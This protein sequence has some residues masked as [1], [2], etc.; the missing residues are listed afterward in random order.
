ML[1]CAKER[2]FGVTERDH[3]SLHDEDMFNFF[4]PD[5]KPS[6]CVVVAGEGATSTLH[7][8]P[9]TWTG[10]SLCLEG[11]KVWRFIAPP[12]AVRA[13]NDYC[14]DSNVKAIDDAVK[15]YRLPS[16]AWESNTFLSSGWQS[17]MSLFAQR[18]VE[19]RSAESFADLEEKSPP[20]K[21]EEMKSIAMGMDIIS[22]SLDFP[23]VVGDGDE[24]PTIYAIV[25][26]PGDLLIIPAYWWHQTFAL[27]PS[28]AIASQ[29]AGRYRDAKRII[30][31]ILETMGME[32]VN[33]DELPSTLND[34]L[35]DTHTG[36]LEDIPKALFRYLACL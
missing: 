9:Y 35:N 5:L 26:E 12:G 36:P 4:P 3:A 11:T 27:E 29:R 34:V 14:H 18:H 7:R 32:E 1:R 16:S 6:D 21:Y 24:V 8:D 30:M 23:S 13:C 31:H 10:T 2:P 33:A 22:P 25:Q 17:D 20:E 19:I 15:S 28:I